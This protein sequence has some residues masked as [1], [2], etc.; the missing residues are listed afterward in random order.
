MAFKLGNTTLINNSKQIP[1]QDDMGF[2]RFGMFHQD[3]AIEQNIFN[4]KGGAGSGVWIGDNQRV[5]KMT[6][7]ATA[8]IHTIDLTG[9]SSKAETIYIHSWKLTSA[10]TT[11]QSWRCFPHLRLGY[12]SSGTKEMLTGNKYRCHARIAGST[13]G[14][15]RTDGDTTTNTYLFPGTNTYPTTGLLHD[16]S[17]TGFSRGGLSGYIKL[18]N[19]GDGSRATI[20]ESLLI[21][22]NFGSQH[23]TIHSFGVYDD[24]LM[25]AL[26]HDYIDLHLPVDSTTPGVAGESSLQ[27]TVYDEG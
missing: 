1:A 5:D 12:D 6:T 22:P 23:V 3:S 16:Q 25:G 18:W 13:T 7:T 9:S 15:E 11:T 4:P 24:S 26:R 21:L 17:G 8:N 10:P 14:S 27:Y 19:R 20:V 2:L